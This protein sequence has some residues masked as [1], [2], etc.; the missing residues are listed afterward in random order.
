MNDATKKNETVHN[1]PLT[2]PSSE[3]QTFVTPANYLP[4]QNQTVVYYVPVTST[5]LSQVKSG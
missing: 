3:N 5:Q 2:I 1:I 4:S